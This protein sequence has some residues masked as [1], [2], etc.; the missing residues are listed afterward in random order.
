[1]GFTEQ[2]NAVVAIY[3]YLLSFIHTKEKTGNPARLHKSIASASFDLPGFG[4]PDVN[5]IELILDGWNRCVGG[6]LHHEVFGQGVYA[7]L[8][9]VRELLK[10]F[11]QCGERI[12][13]HFVSLQDINVPVRVHELI[14]G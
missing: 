12:L 7:I 2:W 13:R 1:M 10:A 14:H 9:A 3:S 5:L 11:A 4:D 8:P 6:Q